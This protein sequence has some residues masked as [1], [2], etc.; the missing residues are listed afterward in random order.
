MDLQL[1]QC[2][3]IVTGGGRGIGRQICLTLAQEGAAVAIAD[4]DATAAAQVAAE[5]H[6]RSQRALAVPTDVTDQGAVQTLM[7]QTT[8]ELGA[9]DILVNNAGIGD[10]KLFVDSS[11][12]DWEQEINVNL[13]AVL[14]GCYAVLPQMIE[15]RTGTIITIASDAARMGQA[16]LAYYAAA[17]AGA[18]A[19][20]KSLA[21]EVGRYGI[22][23]NVVS[24]SATNTEL[25]QQR[26]EQ[27]RR[28]LGE[29]GYAQRQRRVL[30]MYP[31]RR[32]GEP[33]DIA[34]MV[35]FLAS[36]NW[37][38][39]ECQWRLLHA[40]IMMPMLRG[41]YRSDLCPKPLEF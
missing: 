38:G 30:A 25:R 12:E 11:P 14:H 37:P 22:T 33:E 32:L 36:P 19:F 39:G 20:S 16:R 7:Q 27:F 2:V 4:I 18:I 29:E 5:I 23:V 26:E 6:A 34:N 1:Q 28:E 9:V 24:P 13:Y 17:K 21:Q 40:V 31:V 8:R 35:V 41:F 3:A 15:R 10:N